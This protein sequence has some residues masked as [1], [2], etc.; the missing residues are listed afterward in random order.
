MARETWVQSQAESYQTLRKWFSVSPCLTLSIIR[1][2]SLIKWGNSRKGVTTTPTHLCSGYRNGSQLYLYNCLQI[3][4]WLRH[5]ITLQVGSRNGVVVNVLDCDAE[6][7]CLSTR[8]DLVLN[9]ESWNAVKQTGQHK[10]I[11]ECNTFITLSQTQLIGK[12]E[13]AAY[14]CVCVCVCVCVTS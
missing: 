12:I 13:G 14:T 5:K 1:L 2:G 7:N 10:S 4:Y 9:N 6:I 11:F 8:R 3:P